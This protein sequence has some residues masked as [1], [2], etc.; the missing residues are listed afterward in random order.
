[1]VAASRRCRC[2]ARA[3]RLRRWSSLRTT[4]GRRTAYTTPR[5]RGAIR[6]CRAS[7]A[8]TTRSGIPMQRPQ[9]I[10]DRLYLND[11][12]CAARQ[13][14]IR[15]ASSNARER[16]R[17]V[18][19][20]LRPP[21]LPPDLAHRRS[22][23]R[24]QPAVTPEAQKRRAPA[25]SGHVRRRPVRHDRGLHAL[26]PLHHAR[27][28][29][30][31]AARHLRQR[32]PHRPGAGHGGDQLRDDSRHARLLHR[33]PAAHRTGDPSVSRRLARALGRRRARRRDD[34]PHRQDQHRR[35]TATACATATR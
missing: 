13:K 32:Q 9:N 1:M 4:A 16:R 28:R 6:I 3:R 26:R 15:R 23:G 2:P 21:R 7:G 11:E 14:Q 20:R 34:E 19:R 30:L 25:R 5:R 17:L 18:P 24:P 31:G 8:A 35:R 27:H 29:R 33:R 12:Q 10:G 22:A